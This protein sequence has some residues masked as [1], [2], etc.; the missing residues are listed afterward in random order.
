MLTANIS[1]LVVN[2]NSEAQV[3][4]PKLRVFHKMPLTLPKITDQVN[5]VVSSF[6][7]DRFIYILL[8]MNNLCV[9]GQ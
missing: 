1:G 9:H 2:P 8:D 5:A 6:K 7:I 4:G 3:T